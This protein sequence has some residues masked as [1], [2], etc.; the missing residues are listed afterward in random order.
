MWTQ[1][2]TPASSTLWLPTGRP[3][4]VSLSTARLTSGVI[5]LGWLKWRLIHSGWYF[6][7]ISH[8]SSSIR[9]GRKTG[10]REP[11]RMISMCGISRRPRRIDLEQLRRERQAVAARDEDVAHLR[12]PA[13]VL[14]LGLVVAA[15]EVLGR[16]AD[17]PRSR[18]VAAVAGAL[19]RDQHQDAIRVAMDEAGHRRVAVLGERVLHHRGEGLVLATARDDL[20]ADRVVGVLGVDQADE[21]GRDVDPELVGRRQAVAL[22]V[23][24]LE[25]LLDLGEVVD[26]MAEL[27]APVVPLRVGDVVP[28]RRAAADGRGAV[29][30]DRARRIGQVDERRLGRAP[31]GLLVRDRCLDLLGVQRGEPPGSG[32]EPGRSGPLD[33]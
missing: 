20:A 11:I 12:R 23:G 10:T 1:S 2:L 3:A 18:A 13:Q 25:D 17:D 8:S 15:V 32:V 4:L 28:D 33:A 22:V 7:S 27:P 19:G 26:P 30:A 29:G 9:C 21:V 14:E 24:Q 5:S 16:V 6:S 31:G